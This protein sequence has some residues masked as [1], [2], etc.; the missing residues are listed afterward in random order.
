VYEATVLSKKEVGAKFEEKNILP[1]KADL[2]TSDPVVTKAL[3]SFQRVGVPLYVLYRPGEDQPVVADAI[4]PGW[5]IGEL[6]K[7]KK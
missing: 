7:I 5:L 4:T 6:D 3:Q 1:L 2:T